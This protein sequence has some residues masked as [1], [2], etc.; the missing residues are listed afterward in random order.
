MVDLSRGTSGVSLNR[1][2]S[3]IVLTKAREGSAFLARATQVPL[4]GKGATL[5]SVGDI[6][7]DWVAETAKKAVKT[8]TIGNVTL[9]P[10]KVAAIIPMSK[11]IIRDASQ[12]VAAITERAPGSIAETVN[13]TIRGAT[14]APGADFSQFTSGIS[15]ITFAN[16]EELEEAFGAV[17][18]AGYNPDGIVISEQSLWKLRAKRLSNGVREFDVTETTIN[19]LPYSS[20]KGAVDFIAVGDFNYALYGVVEGVETAISDQAT[21]GS[22]E[23]AINLWQ[24]NMVA[25]RVEA[26]V[27]FKIADTGAFR[28]LTYGVSGS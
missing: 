13:R 22:G 18:S 17:A 12:L 26:E 2:N 3:Q 21:L 5:H 27:A 6:A 25:L 4:S 23:E 14:T 15:S 19:G 8:P 11:E 7:A 16:A 20:F 1:E 28:L 10:Y 24:Q 9:T